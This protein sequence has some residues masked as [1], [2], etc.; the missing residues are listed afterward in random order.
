L[1]LPGWAVNRP[2][3]SDLYAYIGTQ[4]PKYTLLVNGKEY[5]APVEDGYLVIERTWKRE[6]K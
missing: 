5:S 6:I 3:P 2:V 1:R 4:S